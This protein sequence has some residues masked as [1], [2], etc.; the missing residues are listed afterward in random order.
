MVNILSEKEKNRRLRAVKNTIKRN[1][2]AEVRNIAQKLGVDNPDALSLYFRRTM[3]KTIKQYRVEVRLENIKSALK[4]LPDLKE[5]AVLAGFSNVGNMNA[6]LKRH[7]NSTISEYLNS[8]EH[9]TQERQAGP[10]VEAP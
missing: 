10:I 3:D 2:K 6:Y 7:D 8:P 1:P 4:S 5:A 9:K